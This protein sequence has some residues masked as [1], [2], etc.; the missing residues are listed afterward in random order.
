MSRACEE[1]HKRVYT[2][3]DGEIGRYRKW[4]IKR[5]L[6][7][8]P[9]CHGGFGFEEKLKMKIRGD[10]VDDVPEE[11]YDRLSAFLRDN[12]PTDASADPNAGGSDV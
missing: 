8:C 7:R 9:P 3:L 4:K 10:C 5:H 11:L 12:G 2:Y 6:R 1:A